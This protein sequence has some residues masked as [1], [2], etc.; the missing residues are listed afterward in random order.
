[1]NP[2]P[3]GVVERFAIDPSE[4][5][6]VTGGFSGATVWRVRSRRGTLA[7]KRFPAT[8]DVGHLRRINREFQSVGCVPPRDTGGCGQDDPVF[9]DV[10]DGRIYQAARWIESEP[11][12]EDT[13]LEGLL[14]GVSSLANVHSDLEIW[15][16]PTIGRSETVIEPRLHA[17]TARLSGGLNDSNDRKIPA[18]TIAVP[19]SVTMARRWVQTAA[20]AALV[21]IAWRMRRA[22][23]KRWPIPWCL[24]DCHRENFFPN[25]R[26]H[27]PTW[28]PSAVTWNPSAVASIDSPVGWWIDIDAANFDWPGAD[29]ARWLGSFPSACADP[30]TSVERSLDRY[31]DRLVGFDS[32]VFSGD[33]RA[34]GVER[35]IAVRTITDLMFATAWLALLGA[36]DQYDA[37]VRSAEVNPHGAEAS[38]WVRRIELWCRV[39]QT[40]DGIAR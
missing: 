38:N 33:A 25:R 5:R 4:V 20:H 34:L 15:N 39:T 37:F 36:L 27:S 22:A 24:R 2:L 1:M 16:T 3:I 10:C 14:L 18:A 17:A 13:D 6:E 9:V 32:E 26:Q 30:V 19:P 31:H 40:M 21:D 8:V 35:S 23:S 29:L 7:L 28:D 11:F 12:A